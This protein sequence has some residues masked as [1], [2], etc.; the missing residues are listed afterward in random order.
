MSGQTPSI[1]RIVRYTLAGPHIKAHARGEER[2]AM[3]V[4]VFEAVS[5]TPTVNLQVFIDG[6]NDLEGPFDAIAP[7]S[8]L[9]VTSVPYSEEGTF[10]T[11]RWPPRV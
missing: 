10:G 3:I 5:P 9:W 8:T 1:G 11:W 7:P 2:A 6:S 4:R